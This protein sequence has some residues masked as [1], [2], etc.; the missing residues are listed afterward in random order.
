[1]WLSWGVDSA[2]A[3]YLLQQQWHEVVAGF[4]LNYLDESNPN[5]TTKQDLESFHQVREHLLIKNFEIFDFRDQYDTKVLNYIYEWYL[6]GITPNPDVLCNTEIKFKL[7]LQEWINW[8]YDAIAT[9]HYA[10]VATVCHPECSE[11]SQKSFVPQDDS[12]QYHLLR[13]IDHNKD[14]TYFLAWLNQYQLSKSLFPLWEL[15]K[16][17]VRQI[18]HDIWLPN[19]SRPDSQWLCFVWKISMKDF[20]S[21]K[22]WP[23]LWV[24]KK[25]N[26]IIV[27]NHTWAYQYTVGQRR[28]LSLPFQA[29]VCDIDV[30]NNIVYVTDNEDDPKLFQT[31]VWVKDWHWIVPWDSLCMK[32]YWKI[33][34]RQELF[35]MNW[36]AEWW[37]IEWGSVYFDFWKP[38]KWVASGQILA[39]YIWEELIGSGIMI[40]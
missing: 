21:K 37:I 7:F 29:Y 1:M 39:F 4:M 25:L 15:T 35:E 19:A 9:G 36:Y 14:Q 32:G 30:L 3:A 23:K 16:P 5:C 11:G 24:I 12:V 31:W 40:R 18:A 6:S 20:L 13:A 26:W 28:G 17:Q 2:V 33:R 22:I 8:W 38:I 34:Y 10:R 27:W